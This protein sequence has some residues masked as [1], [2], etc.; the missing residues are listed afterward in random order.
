MMVKMVTKKDPFNR[1]ETKTH[2]KKTNELFFQF[3]PNF[4]P[5]IFLELS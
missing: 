3:F 2:K 4:F 1:K 5:N